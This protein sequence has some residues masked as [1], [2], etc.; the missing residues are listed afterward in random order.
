VKYPAALLL[1][2]ALTLPAHALQIRGYNAAVHDRFTG[3]PG[4]PVM[5]P[6]FLHDATKFTGVGWA[7]TEAHK[8]FALVSPRHFVCAAHTGAPPAVGGNLRFIASD[9]SLVQRSVTSLTPIPTDTTGN[10]DI[11]V[12]TLASAV[13]VTVKPLPYLNLA[14]EPGYV[15]EN[16]MVFG[17]TAKAATGTILS[18]HDLDFNNDG[19]TGDTRGFGFL[20]PTSG[21]DPNDCHFEG[22]DS[23]NPTF[24]SYGGQPALVGIHAA[25]VPVGAGNLNLDSFIPHYSVK[26]DQ[27]LAP[28]GY[29]M[30]PA[31][32]TPTSLSFTHSPTPATLQ[33]GSVGAIDFTIENTGAETTGNLAVTLS[34]PTGFAPASITASGCVVEALS[35]GVWSVRKAVV[36]A[37][38]DV[39]INATWTTL[40]NTSELTASVTVESD[41]TTASSYPLNIPVAQ[42]YSSWSQ[43][44]VQAGEDDDP[45]GDGWVNLLEYAF[46]SPGAG[47]NFVLPDGNSARPALVAQGGTVTLSYPERTEAG[48][49]GLT[50]EVELATNLTAGPWTTTLPIGTV[51]STQAYVPAIPGFVKRTLSWPSDGPRRFARVKVDLE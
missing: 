26:L 12:G 17:F 43:G 23:G 42:T 40:P 51:S 10:S 45:D 39:I 3:F 32:F 48:L 38:E 1:L 44:L 7:A 30:R 22:G 29:R 36:A 46:G 35:P 11:L 18:F 25:V 15:G 49:L 19:P 14:G 24:V 16:L 8:Q 4:G 6:T 27:V 21:T 41:T 37:A 20:Y 28:A 34:F 2:P 13:P 31:I 47:G 50:Y 9:G 5:N 33:S